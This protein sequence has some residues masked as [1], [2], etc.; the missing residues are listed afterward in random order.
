MKRQL[1]IL[2]LILLVA[3]CAAIVALLI[4]RQELD[5]TKN[6]VERLQSEIEIARELGEVPL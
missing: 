3:L 5:R 6:E 1:S 2:N 4:S